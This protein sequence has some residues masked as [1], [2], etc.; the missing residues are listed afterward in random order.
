MAAAALLLIIPGTTTDIMGMVILAGIFVKQNLKYR[1]MKAAD[2]AHPDGCVRVQR[3]GARVQGKN[4]TKKDR[5]E[6]SP[7]L[8]TISSLALNPLPCPLT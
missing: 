5:E 3:P 4:K 1:K 7:V 8:F 6:N 2:S